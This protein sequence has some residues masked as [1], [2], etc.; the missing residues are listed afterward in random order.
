MKRKKIITSLILIFIIALTLTG[1]NI[2]NNSNVTKEKNA[3]ELA[4]DEGFNGSL[5]EWLLSMVDTSSYKSI[6]D[7][8]V[9]EGLFSG[10]L[11]EFIA[12]LKGEKG[13]NG[14]EDAANYTINNI[15]RVTSKFTVTTTIRDFW[16]GRTQTRTQEASSAGSGVIIEDDKE[17]G[18]AYIVT[19]YHVVYYVNGDN[20]ISNDIYVYLYGMEYDTFKIKAKYI[21]GSM[22]YDIAVLK[23]ED[24][25]YK[26]SGAYS[27]TI[28]SSNNLKVGS[29]V[30]AVG[31]PEAN[32]ISV[33]SG[34]I[35]VPSETITMT[36][37][38]EMTKIDF[39]VIR[40]DAAVNSGNSGGGLF[41]SEGELIGIVNAKSVDESIEGM[42]YAIPINV[43]Y[44][45][46]KK[47]IDTCDGVNTTTIKKVS[48][49]ANYVIVSSKAIYDVAT[50]TTT[51]TQEI[52][53]DDVSLLSSAYGVLKK[54]D[55][56]IN[57]TYNDITYPITN[58]Y[59][60]EDVLLKCSNGDSIN[61][62]IKR[63]NE[64]QTVSL[65]FNTENT[66]Q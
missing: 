59:S 23:I 52:M 45:V 42:C 40:I 46:A 43:A 20:K 60:L 56:I 61:L 8:A 19:N 41:N 12:S 53:I 22:T 58:I 50:K 48:L 28:G 51:I 29:S 3:Y 6:Y 62:Y 31:N 4:V 32:G 2:K 13:D 1:C 9:N 54:N 44:A 37:S 27:A 25:I 49:G 30:I 47:I 11:S 66:V 36:A 34:V 16:S 14:I 39:R 18:V 63:D 24:D 10:S 38:D 65:T 21:G 5:N 64:Y 17:N 15:V 33:T 35:S 55:I 57:V 26:N 7:L